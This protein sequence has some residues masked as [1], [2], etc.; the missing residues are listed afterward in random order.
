MKKSRK[1]MVNQLQ[2][3]NFVR[4]PVSWKDHPFLFSSFK[5]KQQAQIE[6]IR[7]L[8]IEH[9]FVDI[10]KSETDPL[11]PEVASSKPQPKVDTDLA[12]LTEE[13]Q[14]SKIEKID[15]LKKM[16]R[17]LQ[18]TQQEFD[19]SI[20]KMRNLINKLRSRPLN[21][22]EDGKELIHDISNQLLNT[23]NLV[24]H[25]MDEAKN[26]D[27]IY[28]HSLNVS[29]LSM[30]MAKELGWERNEIE[31][32]GLGAL[33]HDTGK[34]KVPAQLMRK[35]TPLTPPEINFMKQHPIMGAELLKLADTFPEQAQ[36]IV[37]NHHEYLDGSG[38][39]KG[40]KKDSLS[41]LDQLVTAIN[42]YDTL[43]HPEGRNKAKTPYAALGFIYKNYKEKL[44]QEVVGKLIKMLG[45]YPPGS[46][47][48]LSSGQ[49][50]MVMAVNLDKILL[51]RIMV[52]DNL[53]PKEQAPIVDLED[54]KLTIVK[55]IPPA[56]LPEKVMQYLNPRERV[57]YFFGAN[58]KK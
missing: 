32:V 2:V 25:L 38:Y 46:I 21:A 17:D 55:C 57:S 10:D 34:L 3:G 29:I 47:V 27:G 56:A 50:A 31:L 45:I 53:V 6:L 19:R 43:C 39:P 18:K 14:K 24:L 13:M 4:L 42:L 9:V 33:F 26:D 49:F 58:G 44:N 52:Y 36:S 41:K 35:K 20:A 28:Y 15:Q 48:E 7:K 1:V 37:L 12:S 8:G 23:D 11:T 40:L 30:I 16:R 5:L 54:E 51:P 22:I